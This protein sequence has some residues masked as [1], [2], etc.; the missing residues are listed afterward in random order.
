MKKKITSFSLFVAISLVAFWVLTSRDKIP[1]KDVGEDVDLVKAKSESSPVPLRKVQAQEAQTTDAALPLGSSDDGPSEQ[2]PIS[3]PGE[4]PIP[5]FAS[6]APPAGADTL[7]DPREHGG[8]IIPES[9]T[10]TFVP[11]LE[12]QATVTIADKS[13]V[14]TPNQMGGFP[15]I[16]VTPNAVAQVTLSYPTLSPGDPIQ[17]AAPDGGLI[18]GESGQRMVLDESSSISFKWQGNDNLGRFIVVLQAGPDQDYKTLNFWSG[19]RAYSDASTID[20]SP[21]QP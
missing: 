20:R 7:D 13:G 16:V 14:L 1:E 4:P 5:S 11:G 12:A 21:Y 19:P 3:L 15:Q 2:P 8:A 10:G 18:N 9:T 6:F 17:L